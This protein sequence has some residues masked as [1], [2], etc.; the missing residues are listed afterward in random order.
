G[1]GNH[2]IDLPDE[3][4][5][6]PRDIDWLFD[7]EDAKPCSAKE[8]TELEHGA[9]ELTSKLA[10]LETHPAAEEDGTLAHDELVELGVGATFELRV[11]EIECAFCV[12]FLHQS[13]SQ[14]SVE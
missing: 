13:M 14:C 8:P 7:R 5:V 3:L 1:S 10:P 2:E 11:V 9:H 12:E 4:R 6:A